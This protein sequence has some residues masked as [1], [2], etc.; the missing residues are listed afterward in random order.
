MATLLEDIEV[1]AEWL[2]KAFAVDNLKLDYTIHS[3][4]KVDKFFNRNTK[5]GKA[6]KGGRFSQNLGAIIFSIGSYV[7]QTIIKTIPGATWE[8]D[9]NDP[10]GELTAAVKL[11]DGTIMWPMR[12]VLRRFQNGSEDSIYVYGHHVTK[13]L[14]KEEFDLNYWNIDKDNYSVPKRAWWK[15]W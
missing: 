11:P 14:T 3:L 4:I 1:Q 10:Q 12:K 2:A 9:D 15:F 7:G 6:V 8:T 5:D 13:D